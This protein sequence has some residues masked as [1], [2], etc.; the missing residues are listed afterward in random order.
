MAYGLLSEEPVSPGRILRISAGEV[1]LK[2]PLCSE[3]YLLYAQ[4]RAFCVFEELCFVLLIT[5]KK[6][7]RN[8]CL[9]RMTVVME[10]N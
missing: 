6:Q 5:I 7:L 3:I 2:K 10:K 8:T 9:V 1:L 4:G